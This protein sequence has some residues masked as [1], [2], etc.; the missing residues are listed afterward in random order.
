MKDWTTVYKTTI[1]SR[2]EIV[3]GVLV[4]RGIEAVIISKKDTTLIIDN[5]SID[6]MVQKEQVLE[7]MK[8]VKDEITFE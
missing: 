8:I 5:G 3:K 2:A 4:E 1:N 6:V 7:A